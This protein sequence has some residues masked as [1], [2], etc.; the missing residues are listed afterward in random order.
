MFAGVMNGIVHEDHLNY[1][2][3]CM[4]GT[5]KIV[6]D[7]E[8]AVHEFSQ[9]TF[10]SVTAGILDLKM[11]IVDIPLT[12][13]NCGDI[14]QDFTKLF[15]FF[16]IFGNMTLLTQRVTYNMIWYYSDIMVDVNAAIAFYVAEDF[17]NFGDKVGDALVLACGDHSS[18]AKPE[19][20]FVGPAHGSSKP[21][22]Y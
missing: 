5:E 15:N 20:K 19:N 16:T 9:G 4:N 8:D 11:L 13:T 6:T 2:L 22:M 17:Y 21:H 1:L 18:E 10:W 14:P 3:G 12:I 7:V